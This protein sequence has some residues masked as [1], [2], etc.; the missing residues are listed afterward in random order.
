LAGLMEEDV[1]MES[2]TTPTPLRAAF[3]ARDHDALMKAIAP[4]F[5]LNSPILEVPF[6]GIDEASDLFA[7]MLEELWPLT[8]LDEIPGDPHVLHFTGEIRGKRLEG[9][10]L[11]HFDDEGRVKEMTVFFRPLAAVAA[12]LGATGSK[13]GRRRVGPARGAIIAAAGAPANA[14]MRTSAAAAPKLLRLVRAK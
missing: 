3:E 2:G 4:D 14:M 6:A 8:Y 10:D 1:P 12:F 7:V 11:L 13:L 9:V 5:V